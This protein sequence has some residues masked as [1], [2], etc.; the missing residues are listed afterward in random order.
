MWP[1]WRYRRR[2]CSTR[3]GRWT[4]RGQG[5]S[6]AGIVLLATLGA[7]VLTRRGLRPLR[8]LAAGAGEIERTADP[9]QRLPASAAPDEIGQLTGV[10]NRMLGALEDA[11][12]GER[13]FLADAS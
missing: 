2:P 11:R 1:S 9:A 8:R 3:R 12:A 7:A 5:V 4:V 6:G 13:R 10:L